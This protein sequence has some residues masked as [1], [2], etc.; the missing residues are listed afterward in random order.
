MSQ[1]DQRR[2]TVATV[3]PPTDGALPIFAITERSDRSDGQ[4]S[5]D[6]DGLIYF[7]SAACSQACNGG[8]AASSLR[9]H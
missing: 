9:R 8:G 7:R 3:A 5:V 1:I 2:P 4:R 6:A